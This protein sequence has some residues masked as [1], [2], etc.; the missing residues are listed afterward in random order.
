MNTLT[1]K[2]INQHP[3]PEDIHV[4]RRNG[5]DR[6]QNTSKSDYFQLIGGRRKSYCRRNKDYDYFVDWYQPVHLAVAASIM[7]LSIFD[8]FMTT[9]ILSLGGK[10][11][12]VLMDYAI[13]NDFYLFVKV[14][15]ALTGLSIIFLTRYIHFKIFN[16]FKVFHFMLLALTGYAALIAYEFSCLM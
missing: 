8:A 4:D 16:L 2:N 10:E 11:I 6:R 3:V 14:K 5:I 1:I 12:N 7:L 9:T 15:L 13:Q